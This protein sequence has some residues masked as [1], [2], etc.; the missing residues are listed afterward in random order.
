V[1]GAEVKVENAT[2]DIRAVA[3]TPP[4]VETAQRRIWAT[5]QVIFEILRYLR[6][7]N[8]F[9]E[10]LDIAWCY[11]AVQ[12]EHGIDVVG[13]DSCGGAGCKD[14]WIMEN[15]NDDPPTWPRDFR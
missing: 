9:T 10:S 4:A 7:G 15:R 6:S 8:Q 12:S 14:H 2:S 13:D 5:E 1:A 11:L 3:A